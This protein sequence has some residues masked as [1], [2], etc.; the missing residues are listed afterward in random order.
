MRVRVR[1]QAREH[2]PPHTSRAKGD[3]PAI[4]TIWERYSPDRETDRLKFLQ[5]LFGSPLTRFSI[6][7]NLRRRR[8]TFSVTESADDLTSLPL[9]LDG[10]PWSL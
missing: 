10:L 8:A 4:T 9:R 6:V 3:A 2:R 1:Q 7:Q 5:E